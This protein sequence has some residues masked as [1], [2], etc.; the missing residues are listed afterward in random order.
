MRLAVSYRMDE[1]WYSHSLECSRTLGYANQVTSQTTSSSIHLPRWAEPSW[2]LHLIPIPAHRSHP[3]TNF[4]L[5]GL[6]LCSVLQPGHP[7]GWPISWPGRWRGGGRTSCLYFISDFVKA[8]W[9][10]SGSSVQLRRRDRAGVSGW[11]WRNQ[12]WFWFRKVVFAQDTLWN[13]HVLLSYPVPMT[14]IPH[15]QSDIKSQL[16][17]KENRNKHLCRRRAHD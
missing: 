6:P 9:K 16:I 5:G 3:P 15:F 11:W 14:G 17:S 4:F 10:K 2:I 1:P 13:L 8:A 7:G 12:Y